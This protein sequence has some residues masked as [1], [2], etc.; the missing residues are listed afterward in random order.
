MCLH[1]DTYLLRQHIPCCWSPWSNFVPHLADMFFSRVRFF[2]NLGGL[3]PAD[4]NSNPRWG[5]S[6]QDYDHTVIDEKY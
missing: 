3:G 5:G 4:P 1:I 2:P 6:S